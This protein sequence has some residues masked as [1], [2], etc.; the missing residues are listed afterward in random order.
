MSLMG[1]GGVGLKKVQSLIDSAIETDA[2][3]LYAPKAHASAGTTY[4]VGSGTNYGHVKLSDTVSTSGASAGVA[5][6]PKCVKDAVSSRGTTSMKLLWTNPDDGSVFDDQTI[7][8]NL[9]KYDGVCIWCRT[10]ISTDYLNGPFVAPKNNPYRMTGYTTSWFYRTF[11][12][13]DSG[14]Q[15]TSNNNNGVCIPK[16][17][18]GINF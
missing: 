16:Y 8:L 6:T 4:G 11:T 3:K 13:T 17:I 10:A 15:F 18:Y 2:A 7:K 1:S 14:V 12:C 9:S 5:A